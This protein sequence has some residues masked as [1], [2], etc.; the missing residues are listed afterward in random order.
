MNIVH[1]HQQRHA[2]IDN[3]NEWQSFVHAADIST[4]YE[5]KKNYTHIW[6]Q[7]K[8]SQM[9]YFDPERKKKKRNIDCFCST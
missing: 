4:K 7:N 3:T 8:S 5:E 9:N 6:K 1:H 2:I